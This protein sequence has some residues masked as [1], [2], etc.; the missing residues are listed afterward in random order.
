MI[1]A[2]VDGKVY[3]LG[4]FNEKSQVVKGSSV[5]DMMRGTWSEGPELPGGAMNGFG[6]AAVVVRSA[7]YVSVDNGGLY[8]LNERAATWTKVGQAPPRIV[9]R[10]VPDGDRILIAG[11]ASGGKN[12]DLIEAIAVD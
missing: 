3:V 5:Y 4:G 2:A 8:R 1:A 6:P 12:F 10:L 9:H 11:G 7:L